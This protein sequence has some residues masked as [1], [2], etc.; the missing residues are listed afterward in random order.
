MIGANYQIADYNTLRK[1]KY[2]S[3]FK[4]P[5]ACKA[6]SGKPK[7]MKWRNE[8]MRICFFFLDWPV[9]QHPANTIPQLFLQLHFLKN[10]YYR[11]TWPKNITLAIS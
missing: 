5:K 2:L 9:N 1:D 7:Y 11:Y 10:S 4:I 8:H 3:I 6:K